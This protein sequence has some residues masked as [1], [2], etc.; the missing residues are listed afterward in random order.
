[1]PFAT[2]KL[3]SFM[4]NSWLNIF[5]GMHRAD[6]AGNSTAWNHSTTKSCHIAPVDISVGKAGKLICTLVACWTHSFF[7][8]ECLCDSVTDYCDSP[9][10]YQWLHWQIVIYCGFLICKIVNCV[11]PR[12]WEH[13]IILCSMPGLSPFVWYSNRSAVVGKAFVERV[14]SGKPPWSQQPSLLI[15]SDTL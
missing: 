15:S 9:E 14:W 4:K 1:M 7:W 10:C 6:S 13:T 11:W 2:L 3:P 12:N 8:R 5:L